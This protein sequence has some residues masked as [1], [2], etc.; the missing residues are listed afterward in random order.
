MN[1]LG[2]KVTWQ[3]LHEEAIVAPNL[4]QIQVLEGG[5]YLHWMQTKQIAQG[6]KVFIETIKK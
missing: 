4:Q 1:Q 6:A 3:G 5:H 2:E